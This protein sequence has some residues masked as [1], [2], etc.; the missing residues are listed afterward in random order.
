MANVLEGLGVDLGHQLLQGDEWN[1]YGYFEDVP[2]VGLNEAILRVAGG[3]WSDP[4]T[5]LACHTAGEHI[6]GE[7]ARYC[8]FRQ[9][10]MMADRGRRT[11]WG[12]KDPRLCLTLGTWLCAL[13]ASGAAVRVVW[14]WRRRQDVVASLMRRAA[15]GDNWWLQMRRAE[16]WLRLV[17]TYAGR[18]QASLQAGAPR[19]G[20]GSGWRVPVYVVQFEELLRDREGECRKLAEWLGLEPMLAPYV[21]QR[22]SGGRS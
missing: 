8:A 17:A 22:V 16:D 6:V 7:V 13:R 18:L 19:A 5:A 10:Q 15:G 21:A 12:V 11:M 20:E 2:A 14:V 1:R 9:R 3:T 4:P